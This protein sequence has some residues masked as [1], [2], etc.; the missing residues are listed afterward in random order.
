MILSFARPTTFGGRLA[1][2][3]AL[4]SIGLL[5][6]CL[7][8]YFAGG[9]YNRTNSLPKGLYWLVDKEPERGDIVSFWPDGSEAFR[10]AR[11]R[12]YLIPGRYNDQG[13]GGYDAVMKKLLGLPGDVVSITEDGVTINGV[14]VPNSRPFVRDNIGDPLPVIR[15]HDYRLGENEVLFLSDHLPRSFD[16]RYFGVQEKGQ[17]IDVLAPVLTW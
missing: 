2:A 5:V 16:A 13:D 11:K 15:L 3:F 1:R 7:A 17:I 4:F 9:R 8:V 10:I 12:G 6:V 14:P